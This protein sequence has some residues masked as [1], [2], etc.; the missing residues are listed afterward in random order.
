MEAAPPPPK[1][2]RGGGECSPSLC[3]SARYYAACRELESELF[4]DPWATY[5]AGDKG[6]QFLKAVS[7]ATGAH[8]D[9]YAAFANSRTAFFDHLLTKHVQRLLLLTNQVQVVLVGVGGDA[10]PFRLQILKENKKKIRIFELDVQEVIDLRKQ[11]FQEE[12]SLNVT[13][14]ASDLSSSREWIKDLKVSGFD[15]SIPSIWVAEGFVMYL[16]DQEQF[17]RDVSSAMCSQSVFI[18]DFLTPSFV[19]HESVKDLMNIWKQWAVLPH[20]SSIADLETFFKTTGFSEVTVRDWGDSEVQGHG[21]IPL[22]AHLYWKSHPRGEFPNEPRSIFI[23]AF[24][25]VDKGREEEVKC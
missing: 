5:F 9:T 25:L 14:I 8:E 6:R 13:H 18:G 23:E 10:R 4:N 20:A 12:E 22:L 19:Q 2:R 16:K 21:R 7:E 1:R 11:V 15:D 17:V 3:N 24:R